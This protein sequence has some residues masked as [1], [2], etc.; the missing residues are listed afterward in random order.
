MRFERGFVARG[1]RR[2]S[3]AWICHSRISVL[4]VYGGDLAPNVDFLVEDGVLSTHLYP[5][6]V[7]RSMRACASSPDRMK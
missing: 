2:A 4:R 3:S 1:F 5:G 7:K 6:Y